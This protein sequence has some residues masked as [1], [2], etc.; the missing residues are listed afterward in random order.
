MGEVYRATDTKLGRDVALK[1]LPPEM[2]SSA[3][4]VDRFRR[5]ARAVAALNHPHIV[6]IHSVEEADGVHF[7]TMELVEGQPL[8]RRIPEQGLPLSPLLEIVTALADALAAA[9][10]KGIVHRDLKPANVMVTTDGRAK[11]L[12]FGLAKL[13]PAA[14]ESPDNSDRPTEMQTREGIVMGTVPYMSPEQLQGRALDHRTDI[15]SLGVMLFEMATGRRPFQG[16]SSAEL[17][18]SI[19]RDA[20]PA[21]AELRRD[22]PEGLGHLIQRCLQKSAADR[23]PSARDLAEGLRVVTREAEPRTSTAMAAGPTSRAHKS[24]SIA[25]LPFASMS[26]SQDDEYFCDGLAEE[27]LTALSRVDALKVA[28]RTSAFSFKGKSADVSTIATALGVDNVL[29]GSFRRSGHR[30]RITLQLISAADGCQRWSERYDREMSDIFALQDEIALAVVAALKLTLFGD[31]KAAVLLRRYTDDAETYELF[32]KGRHHS[33]AYTAEGWQ[34][35]IE[36]FT[37]AIE[38]QPEYALAHAGIAAA[39]GCQWF[40]GILPAEQTV[41]QAK[42]VSQQAL[43]IDDGLADAHQSQAMLAF[44]YDWDWRRAEQEFGRSF[45]LNPNNA[46]A[47]SYYAMFLAFAGRVDEALQL[48]KK[49]LTLDP[50]A[51]LVNMNGGWTYYAAGMPAEALQ[52]AARMLEIDPAFYGSYWLQGAIHLGA[53]EYG[54]AVEQLTTAVSLGGHQIVVADLAS[55]HALAGHAEAAAAILRQLLDRRRQHYVP[56]ICLARVYCRIGETS[57]ALTW[58]EA[59]FAERNGELV[60]LQA[61]LAGAADDDP[62]RALADEPRVV[63]LLQGMNLP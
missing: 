3:E 14:V 44:F 29:E 19:L 34:R 16:H 23:F 46:E 6:T 36:F 60:F 39:R 15:F 41:P 8:N 31:Q 30:V 59:A 37:K 33:Y 17:A 47:L 61:E 42:A 27:L 1:V 28:A 25:V 12:D 35:A 20:P 49:A 58:L 52:Q 57:K 54:R 13:T 2:A 26:A 18:S 51:P 53:G 11:I 9:H 40:F 21:L 43:A 5:E 7:L 63:A 32:L 22:L 55:A 56:A 48:N 62:L 4:Q 38:R 10:E 24:T 50:L 45:D